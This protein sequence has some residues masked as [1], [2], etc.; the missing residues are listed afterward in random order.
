MGAKGADGCAIVGTAYSRIG[1]QPAAGMAALAVEACR[2]A[3]ADA[4]LRMDDIDGFAAFHR[5]SESMPGQI[6]GIDFA[7]AQLAVRLFGLR[8]VAWFCSV[9]RGLFVA[10][11]VEAMGAIRTG[12]C[13][14]VVVLRALNNPTSNPWA[15]FVDETTP[16]SAAHSAPYGLPALGAPLP[17]SQYISRYGAERHAMASVVAELRRNAAAN[18]NA[19]FYQHSFREDDYLSAPMI[20]DPLCVHDIDSPVSG[21]AALVLTSAERA[22]DLQWPPAY[23]AAHA[24]LGFDFSGRGVLT[25]DSMMESARH[26]AATVWK[27]SGIGPNAV[28]TVQLYDSYSYLLYMWLEA[29]GFCDAGEAHRFVGDG[30]TSVNG[31]LPM[32]TSGGS[33]GMGRLHGAAQVIEGVLQLQNRC[34]LRQVKGASVAL[35]TVGVPT[36]GAGGLLLTSEPVGG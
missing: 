27:G 22:R 9:D 29:F 11:V 2:E 18:P 28:D 34:D 24:S 30:R 21:A 13:K 14:Y 17:Y 35:V 15:R 6:E 32:N 20:M 16:I 36:L 1:R 23:V 5:P 12:T 25:W 8:D 4:G 26:L 31:A 3:V 33:L 7:G 19:L 10:A